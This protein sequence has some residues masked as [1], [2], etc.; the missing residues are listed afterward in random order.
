MPAQVFNIWLTG[1]GW[2]GQDLCNSVAVFSFAVFPEQLLSF[3]RQQEWA[4]KAASEGSKCLT[5]KAKAGETQV[6]AAALERKS[7][8]ELGIKT[9]D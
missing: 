9:S 2:E 3:G 8:G 7:T 5:P 6:R 1:T 4:G